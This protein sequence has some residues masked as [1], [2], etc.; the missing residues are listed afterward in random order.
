M[1]L[2]EA[3][4][5]T[6]WTGP[7]SWISCG[8]ASRPPSSRRSEARGHA[9]RGGFDRDRLRGGGD[10]FAFRRS[11]HGYVGCDPIGGSGPGVRVVGHP[12]TSLRH[13]RGATRP[14]PARVLSASLRG[15]PDRAPASQLRGLLRRAEPLRAVAV[16]AGGTPRPVRPRAHRLEG[17]GRDPGDAGGCVPDDGRAHRRRP[18]PSR[19]LG[20]VRSSGHGP[21]ARRS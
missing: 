17:T 21:R 7:P 10:P 5:A 16:P 15:R 3:L 1:D 18:S 12:R 6:A 2:H 19:G 9:G 4:G 14:D 20:P 13:P 8:S 11:R